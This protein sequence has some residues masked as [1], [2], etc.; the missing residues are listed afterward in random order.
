MSMQREQRQQERQP[1]RDEASGSWLLAW[2]LGVIAM[3][4]AGV[5]SMF[6]GKSELLKKRLRKANGRSSPGTVG[7]GASEISSVVAYLKKHLG[8]GVTAYLSGADDTQL[9]ERWAAG[10]AQPTMLPDLRL[11]SAYQAA[12]YVV[13]AY[14]D[15]TA[16]DWFFGMNPAL[17]DTAPAY[18]LRHGSSPEHWS[19][20]VPAAMEFVEMSR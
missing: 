7:L 16:Q 4:L 13:E 8:Q 3:T 18:V 5:L 2:A 12:R 9:V 19:V 15:E 10:K 11:R 1:S 20:V 6:A 14:G 17:A